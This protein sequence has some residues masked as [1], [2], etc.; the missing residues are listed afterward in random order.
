MS[1]RYEFGRLLG[2]TAW[3]AVATKRAVC[4]VITFP[5]RF[6]YHFFR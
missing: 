3:C 4:D 1:M 2:K 5:F 6:L